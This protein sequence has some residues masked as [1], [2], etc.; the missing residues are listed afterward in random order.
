MT[1]YDHSFDKLIE[2][3][4][5]SVQTPPTHKDP[6][7]TIRDPAVT[8]PNC[9]VNKNP[10]PATHVSRYASTR[11]LCPRAATCPPFVPS[12][13]P[14][15]ATSPTA[16]ASQMT[17]IAKNPIGH[18]ILGQD[19]SKSA[20]NKELKGRGLGLIAE[21]AKR[22]EE[23]DKFRAK[24]RIAADYDT[25]S[26][27]D[28]DSLCIRRSVATNDTESILKGRLKAHDRRKYG[29]EVPGSRLDPILLSGGP[30]SALDNEG[31]RKVHNKRPLL[32]RRY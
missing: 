21:L 29:T 32:P 20:T 12:I 22:L 15:I 13:Q 17:N 5:R 31:S 8:V 9:H 25:M 2:P 27:R 4:L 1:D 24:A 10:P 3:C 11:D 28:I 30:V 16:Y 23:D 26:P 18:T 7:T 6:P 19:T 14:A